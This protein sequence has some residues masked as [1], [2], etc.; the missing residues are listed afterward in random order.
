ANPDR[1]LRFALLSDWT[2]ADSATMADDEPLLA[3]AAEGIARLNARY[4]DAGQS[5]DRFYLFHRSRRWNES[6]QRWMGWERKRGKLHELN[7]LL[8]GGTDTS[9]VAPGGTAPMPP[10]AVRDVITLDS[11]TRLPVG[12]ARALI[13]TIAHPLN[14]AQYDQR[15]GRVVDGYGVLQPRVMPTLPP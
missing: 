8:R 3:R 1:E 15:V 11:D 9:F 10:S 12:G 13:G 6:E 14:R 2:D 7:H 5:E 4:H